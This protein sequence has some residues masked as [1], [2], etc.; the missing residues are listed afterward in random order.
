MQNLTRIRYSV[1]IWLISFS[2]KFLLYFSWFVKCTTISIA[3]LL[4]ISKGFSDYD[5]SSEKVFDS[6]WW[7]LLFML[8][9]QPK[10]RR[11]ALSFIEARGSALI[12]RFHQDSLRAPECNEREI[13]AAS[14]DLPHS[15]QWSFFLIPFVEW[16][17]FLIIDES[18]RSSSIK[19]VGKYNILDH[20]S[21]ILECVICTKY[22]IIRVSEINHTRRDGTISYRIWYYSILSLSTIVR[23]LT[24]GKKQTEEY[25]MHNPLLLQIYQDNTAKV[26]LSKNQTI[27]DSKS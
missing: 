9:L 16:W 17:I 15:T 5:T 24:F 10:K 7:S 14:E 3:D 11:S 23:I 2:S 25:C 1:K 6:I 19:S 4:F 18:C 26:L 20:F 21:I 8:F 12:F 27:W 22:I 13:F